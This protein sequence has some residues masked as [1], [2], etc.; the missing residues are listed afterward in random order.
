MKPLEQNAVPDA[1]DR[2]ISSWVLSP[3]HDKR[4]IFLLNGVIHAGVTEILKTYL[5][6]Y[7]FS[8]NVEDCQ[9]CRFVCV[10]AIDYKHLSI[11]IFVFIVCALEVLLLKV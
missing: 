6:K 4:K 10:S 8:K 1:T 2:E 9:L 3:V 5:Y 7:L 11:F